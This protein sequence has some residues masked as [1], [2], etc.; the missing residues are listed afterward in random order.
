MLIET[1][2]CKQTQF[3]E[4]KMIANEEATKRNSKACSTEQSVKTK[5][6]VNKR[7]HT[8][9]DKL[10]ERAVQASIRPY[11]RRETKCGNQMLLVNI[12][13]RNVTGRY[14]NLR[15]SKNV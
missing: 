11:E 15:V 2:V 9:P 8:M 14:F 10:K 3:N 13:P 4:T 6:K 7:K 1:K 12:S 5:T